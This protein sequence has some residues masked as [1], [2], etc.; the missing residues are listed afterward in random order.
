MSTMR[1]LHHH[2]GGPMLTLDAIKAEIEQSLTS[3]PTKKH[4]SVRWEPAPGIARVGVC[5]HDYNWDTR[6]QVI[7]QLLAFEDAHEGEVA[8]EFDIF[9]LEDVNTVGFAEV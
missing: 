4:V 9:S 6:E 7:D 3:L 1:S 8:L 2:S 5:I